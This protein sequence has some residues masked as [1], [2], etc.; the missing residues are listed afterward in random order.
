M[1]VSESD[2]LEWVARQWQRLSGKYCESFAR[3]DVRGEIYSRQQELL[4]EYLEHQMIC[5]NE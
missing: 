3:T 2:A 1:V 5:Y 4:S